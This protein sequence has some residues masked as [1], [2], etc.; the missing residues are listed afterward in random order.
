MRG[1]NIE[2]VEETSLKFHKEVLFRQAHCSFAMDSMF[3]PLATSNTLFSEKAR[4]MKSKKLRGVGSAATRFSSTI[5]VQKNLK[6]T[7]NACLN[8]YKFF[9]FTSFSKTTTPLFESKWMRLVGSFKQVL[10][11]FALKMSFRGRRCLGFGST[12]LML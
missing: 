10:T 9:D 8:S 1:K 6:T 3:I 2:L 7:S 11:I 5:T 12:W 4:H